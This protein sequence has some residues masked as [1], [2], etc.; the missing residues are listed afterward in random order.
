[1][2]EMRATC[3]KSTKIKKIE[4]EIE[5]APESR[6]TEHKAQRKQFHD[7]V[8]VCKELM[9]KSERKH[10]KA[11]GL[12][13]TWS[14]TLITHTHTHGTREKHKKNAC[15]QTRN[16]STGCSCKAQK[17][18]VRANPKSIRWMPT[19]RKTDLRWQQMTHVELKGTFRIKFPRY[20]SHLTSLNT[21]IDKRQLS[22]HK[23]Q[24]I[25][26]N[27]QHNTKTV[28]ATYSSSLGFIATASIIV[29]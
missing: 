17:K 27:K 24:N 7:G 18:H 3:T 8:N 1:M 29:R 12:I 22:T 4:L 28:R 2:K 26:Q 19:H 6:N 9:I 20:F 21:D 23:K 13:T 11:E 14:I 5:T 16:A 25:G 15:A 10:A